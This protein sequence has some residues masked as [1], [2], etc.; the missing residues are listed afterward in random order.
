MSATG[1]QLRDDALLAIE[2]SNEGQI[3]KAVELIKF[4]APRLL[5]FTTDD[6]FIEPDDWN[7]TD[8]RAIGPAMVRA[9]R[10]G[11]IKGTDRVR[12]S[13]RAKCHARPK[14]VWIYTPK[15]PCNS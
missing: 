13:T 2:T 15:T 9:A 11:I 1:E 10:L 8:N 5:E 6:I 12:K 3:Q 4:A 7:F 14:R